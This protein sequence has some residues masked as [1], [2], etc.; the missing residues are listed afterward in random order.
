MV[1]GTD[2]QKIEIPQQFP[3]FFR[4]TSEFDSEDNSLPTIIHFSVV[5]TEIGK[6]DL[7]IRL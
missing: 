7:Q 2:T 4:F 3:Y 5:Q 1:G 6:L